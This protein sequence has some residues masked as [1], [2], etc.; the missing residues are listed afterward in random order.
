MFRLTL[1]VFLMMTTMSVKADFAISC[2]D[3][4]YTDDEALQTKETIVVDSG[5]G[6][7]MLQTS[8]PQGEE[9]ARY[10]SMAEI[11]WLPIRRAVTKELEYVYTQNHHFESGI[12]SISVDRRIRYIK[13]KYTSKKLQKIIKDSQTVEMLVSEREYRNNCRLLDT[14]EKRSAL[15]IFKKLQE[16]SRKYGDD[17]SNRDDPGKPKI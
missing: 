16:K 6:Q 15:D 5:R 11:Y 10:S 9:S 8:Y 1:L 12:S 13:V 17:G 2:S 14:Q 4:E 7:F 3:D